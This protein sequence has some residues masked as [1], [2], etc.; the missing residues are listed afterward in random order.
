[1]A[2]LSGRTAFVTGG[3]RGIGAS[4]VATLAEAGADVAINYRRDEDAAIETAEAV[5]AFGRRAE[6]YAADVSDF[7]ACEAMTKQALS[8]FVGFDILVNN[9]GIASRGNSIADTS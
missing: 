1:M 7:D 8:D 6:T 5:R 3:G 4:I 2:D 9:G